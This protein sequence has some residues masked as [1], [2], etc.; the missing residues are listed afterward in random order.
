MNQV[1]SYN[2]L[3]DLMEPFRKFLSP[4]KVKFYWDAR[5][6]EIFKKSKKG[7]RRGDCGRSEDIRPRET[8]GDQHRL[9]ADGDKVFPIPKVL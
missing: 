7:D 4:K 2:K 5:M 8:D 1:S 9:F 6:E 3:T